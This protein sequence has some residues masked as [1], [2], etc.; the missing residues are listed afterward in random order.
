MLDERLSRWGAIGVYYESTFIGFALP[1]GGIGPDIVR[2]L[3]LKSRGIDPHVTLSS[4]VM[5]RLNGVLA[6]LALIVAGS[7]VLA[8]LAPQPALRHFAIAS[9]VGAGVAGAIGATLIF[10]ILP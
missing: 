8:R 4:M 5:E 3:R 9:A 10:S 1:L 2:F 7:V 6:T